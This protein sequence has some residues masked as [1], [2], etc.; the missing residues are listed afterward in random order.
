MLLGLHRKHNGC[1]LSQPGKCGGDMMKTVLRCSFLYYRK[2]DERWTMALP[3]SIPLVLLSLFVLFW[4]PKGWIYFTTLWIAIFLGE[5]PNLTAQ[6]RC[7]LDAHGIT[8]KHQRH[9]YREFAWEELTAM[10]GFQMQEQKTL[11]FLC[12]T[13]HRTLR[14]FLNT[15][16]KEKERIAAGYG[17]DPENLSEDA[18]FR[19]MLTAYLW[20][21]ADIE[22]PTTAKVCLTKKSW[23]KLTAF[24][25]EKQLSLQELY[26]K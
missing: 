18:L 23:E 2:Q 22:N 25:Q 4:V 1:F 13:S 9:V 26:V 12:C 8:I 21:K 14:H 3:G 7:L 24:C 5:L 20:R 19:V 10:G 17:Y 16:P 6:P 11:Y 15:H